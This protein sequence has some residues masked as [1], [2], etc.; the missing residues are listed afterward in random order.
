MHLP[1]VT[2]SIP[3][4]IIR[5]RQVALARWFLSFS[6]VRA[7]LALLDF[8]YDF[9]L[10]FRHAGSL[11][12]LA[13]DRAQAEFQLWRHCHRLE[14]AL[15]LGHAEK[16]CSEEFWAKFIPLLLFWTTQ[17]GAFESPLA[18]S[19]SAA[20]SQC[21]SAGLDGKLYALDAFRNLRVY[22]PASLRA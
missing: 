15:A 22:D 3:E 4:P 11:Q 17:P 14:K 2:R 10:W 21:Q 1:A 6:A 8:S 9:W 12:S 19:L 5:P 20:L 16:V 18:C 13:C 7:A